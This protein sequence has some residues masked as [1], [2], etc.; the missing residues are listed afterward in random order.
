MAMKRVGL[1][2]INTAVLNPVQA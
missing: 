2:F 1:R